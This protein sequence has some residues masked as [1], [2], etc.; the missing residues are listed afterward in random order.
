MGYREIVLGLII[1]DGIGD[2]SITI[3]RFMN[4]TRFFFFCFNLAQ[5]SS[6]FYFLLFF[7]IVGS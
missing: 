5:R 6:F 4:E 2:G 3:S 1:R 7:L